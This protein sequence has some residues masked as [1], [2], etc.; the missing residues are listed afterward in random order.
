MTLTRAGGLWATLPFALALAALHVSAPWIRDRLPLATHALTSFGGGVAA[1]YVFLYLLPRLS[2]GNRAV[3]EVLED[4]VASNPVAGLVMSLVTL[5]G[6]VTFYALERV[7]HSS[8][9]GRVE[10][11][12]L[13]FAAQL[14]FF[15]LYSALI[16]YTLATKWRAGVVPALLFAVAMAL[17]LFAADDVLAEHFPVG[18]TGRWRGILAGGALAG[19]LVAVVA[20]PTSTVLVNVLTAFLGGAILLNVFV[21]ELPPERHSSFGWFV[22]G[23]AVYAVLLTAATVTAKVGAARARLSRLSRP[24]RPSRRRPAGGTAVPERAGA[25]SAHRAA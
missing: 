19:W 10:A 25:G 2:E 20:P 8:G 3:A 14:G 12:R 13:V 24:S 15:A 9:Y 4:A 21:H 23:L 11:T 16:T 6:F 7:T 17:H 18:L 22:T 5:L 1:T